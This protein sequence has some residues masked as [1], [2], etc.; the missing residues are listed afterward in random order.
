MDK[1]SSGYESGA[2]PMSTYMLEDICDRSQ[3]RPSIN[4]RDARYKILDCIKERRVEWKGL[5]LSTQNMGKDS[6]KFFKTIFN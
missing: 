3:S 6:Q 5:L 1:M 4:I 2:E